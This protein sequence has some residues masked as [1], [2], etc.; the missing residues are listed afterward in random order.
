MNISTPIST[1]WNSKE[2]IELIKKYSNS[3]EG[4]PSN[5]FYQ[6]TEV[7]DKVLTFHCDIIQPIHKLEQ[8][9]FEY[10]KQIVDTYPNLKIIMV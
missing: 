9:D 5:N 10:I 3:F 2:N 6:Y 1:L 8:S 4:R 7:F